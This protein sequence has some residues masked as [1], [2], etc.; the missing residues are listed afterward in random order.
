MVSGDRKSSRQLLSFQTLESPGR[1]VIHFR[2]AME[3]PLKGSGV[4]SDVVSHTGQMSLRLCVKSSCESGTQ[5]RGA[6]EMFQN[7][8]GPAVFCEM[9]QIGVSI[10]PATTS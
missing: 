1:G 10:H 3:P 4:F 9:G 5:R 6:F 8:L 7:C 2:P